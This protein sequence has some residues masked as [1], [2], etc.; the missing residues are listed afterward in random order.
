MSVPN[1]LQEGHIKNTDPLFEDFKIDRLLD[2]VVVS[3]IHEADSE[4]IKIS[5]TKLLKY[6]NDT[7]IVSVTFL[8]PEMI[9]LDAIEKD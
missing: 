6:S 4:L 2:F 8:F 9:S 5:D 7:L 1:Y 3:Q